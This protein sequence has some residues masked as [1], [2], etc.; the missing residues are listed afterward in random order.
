MK[1][2][3]NYV[4]AVEKAISEKYGKEAVQ[5]F[6][7][8]W[9]TEREESY[10]VQLKNR[11]TKLQTLKDRKKFFL[12]GDVEIKKKHNAE[13]PNRTCPVCKTY[14]FSSRDDL[15]MNRFETC[16]LCYYEFIEHNENNWKQGW[17]PTR[18]QIRESLR[19]RN[20]G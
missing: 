20:N 16:R 19:R 8:T 14:S 7:S 18:E 2:D 5:D 9:E 1:K 15:Y 12:V 13:Q 4:A 11:R 6:R 17:R 10:L 3:L